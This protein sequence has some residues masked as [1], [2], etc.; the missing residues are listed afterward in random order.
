MTKLIPKLSLQV[1][2]I[3]K[4]EKKIVRLEL[5]RNLWVCVQN[6]SCQ[7]DNAPPCRFFH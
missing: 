5:I 6:G 7:I 2:F 4:S 1:L 3:Y